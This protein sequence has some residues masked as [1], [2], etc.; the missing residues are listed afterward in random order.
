MTPS[1]FISFFYVISF[2]VCMSGIFKIRKS[3]NVLYGAAWIPVSALLVTFYQCLFAALGTVLHIPVN[4]FTVG[5]ADG[6]LGFVFW[7]CIMKKKWI[8]HYQYEIIDVMMWVVLTV[9]IGLFAYHR[10]GL[11]MHI[12]YLSIDPAQHLKSAMDTAIGQRVYAMFYACFHNGLLIQLLAPFRD[13]TRYYQIYVLGDVLHLLL[14]GLMFYGVIRQ[15]L[16][17]R[18]LKV[19]SIIVTLIYING[20]PA[21]STIFGFTYLGMCV[22]IIGCTI[23]VVDAFVRDEVYKWMGIAFITL[24][25]LGIFECYVL[26]MPVLFFSIFFCLLYKQYKFAKLISMDTIKICLG[27]FLVP[28]LIGLYFTYNGIFGSNGT[29]VSSAISQE[30]GIYKDLFSNF[31]L[32]LPLAL[33]GYYYL[34]KEKKKHILLFVFPLLACFI[35]ALFTLGMVEKVSSY[36]FYKNY[37]LLWLIV[38]V[39]AFIGLTYLEKKSR[40]LVTFGV[41]IWLFV[42]YVGTSCIETRIGNKNNRYITNNNSYAFCDI[43]IF[44]RDAKAAMAYS[45]SK[46][47]IYQYAMRELMDTDVYIPLA[48][49]W[50]DY[51]WMEAITNQRNRDFEYWNTGEDTFFENLK[52]VDYVMVLEDSDIYQKH[53][54]YF[55]KLEKVFENESGF[56]AKVNK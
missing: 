7:Y 8:Q 31:V 6:L 54:K 32:I 27:T 29:T 15:Y 21:N 25:C 9:A 38:F 40:L 5:I 3:D 52:N 17:D 55:G 35:L 18:F 12:H 33:L 53:S 42:L 22:T 13:P 44:N 51:F 47:K 43:Y 19:A 28:T 41:F 49:S 2:T 45:G 37:Y 14:A 36:Y 50:E 16:K 48:G 4:L 11:D 26:F 20:Y 1:F 30:G 46:L 56:V 23:V 34:L 39:L 24:C 10:Y